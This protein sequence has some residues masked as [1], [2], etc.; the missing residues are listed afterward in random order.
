MAKVGTSERLVAGLQF[1]VHADL[2]AFGGAVAVQH[3]CSFADEP[4][5]VQESDRTG[6]F[7]LDGGLSDAAAEDFAGGTEHRHV[8]VGEGRGDPFVAPLRPDQCSDFPATVAGIFGDT[9][10]HDRLAGGEIG[11][12]E[13]CGVARPWGTTELYA[14]R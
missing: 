2:V 10:G 1:G 5:F 6:R 3:Q 9:D 4:A 8:I 12:G 13:P 14:T 7:G 11:R